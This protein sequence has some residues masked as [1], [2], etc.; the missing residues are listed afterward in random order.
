M[1][2]VRLGGVTY[3]YHGMWYHPRHNVLDLCDFRTILKDAE[4]SHRYRRIVIW[5]SRSKLVR[6]YNVDKD[7][8]FPP[9]RV[10]ALNIAP[11]WARGLRPAALSVEEA[12]S[13]S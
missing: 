7:E 13:K 12:C 4:I 1:S 5:R 10:F 9:L 11:G 6:A 3:S 8:L 2:F